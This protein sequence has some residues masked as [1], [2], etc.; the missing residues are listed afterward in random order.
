MGAVCF[1]IEFLDNQERVTI[2]FPGLVVVVY[3]MP[4]TRERLI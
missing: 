4:E 2:A 1:L 3:V